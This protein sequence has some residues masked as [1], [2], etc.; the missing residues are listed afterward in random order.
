MRTSCA[1]VLTRLHA[2]PSLLLLLL[3]PCSSASQHW[4]AISQS[5]FAPPN[6]ATWQPSQGQRQPPQGHALPNQRF[7][8]VQWQEPRHG[9]GDR[10]A[11]HG[12]DGGPAAAW[13]FPAEPTA[14]PAAAAR[15]HPGHAAAAAEQKYRHEQSM[16]HYLPQP[17]PQPPH[18]Q[19]TRPCLPRASPISQCQLYDQE[20]G[21]AVT[22]MQDQQPA[23][24]NFPPMMQQQHP[25]D[26]WR[27]SNAAG[28]AAAWN[29]APLPSL[30]EA[31]RPAAPQPR[32]PGT[33]GVMSPARR[34]SS[35]AGDVGPWQPSHQTRYPPGWERP[36]SAGPQ[37][38]R[39]GGHPAQSSYS[40]YAAQQWDQGQH[41]GHRFQQ[42][43]EE[44]QRLHQQADDR[45]HADQARRH[46]EQQRQ[47]VAAQQKQQEQDRQWREIR[48]KLAAK[49][50]DGATAGLLSAH[51][52]G[53]A[54]P[55]FLQQ[56]VIEASARCGVQK[57]IET[58]TVC[59]GRGAILDTSD[60]KSSQE[61]G[62]KHHVVA[63]AASAADDD[64]ITNEVEADKAPPTSDSEARVTT[65][66]LLKLDVET[67]V[68]M[69]NGLV[70]ELAFQ[71]AVIRV[72]LNLAL[73][74]AGEAVLIVPRGAS[75]GD[76]EDALREPGLAVDAIAA[77]GGSHGSEEDDG[78]SGA[79][80]ADTSDGEDASASSEVD[81]APEHMT[82]RGCAAMPTLNGRYQQTRDY[83][84]FGV[85]HAVYKSN[86]GMLCFFWKFSKVRVGWWLGKIFGSNESLVGFCPELSSTL[87]ESGWHIEKESR[88]QSDPATFASD[89]ALAIEAILTP[90]P[91]AERINTLNKTVSMFMGSV[92]AE[93]AATTAYFGHFSTLIHLEYLEDV[94]SMRRRLKR[95]IAGLVKGGWA[96][97]DLQETNR[98]P[99]KSGVVLRFRSA[100]KIDVSRTRFKKGDAVVLSKTNPIVDMVADG[101]VV[102]VKESAVTIALDKQSTWSQPKGQSW[103]VDKAANR[104]SYTR[105][106][107]SLEKICGNGLPTRSKGKKSYERPPLFELITSSAVGA[108]DSWA[109]VLKDGSDPG[110][111]TCKSP[112][113]VDPPPPD[114]ALPS[115]P[116]R[117]SPFKAEIRSIVDDLILRVVQRTVAS[118]CSDG[119]GGGG[120]G[121]AG[122]SGSGAGGSANA[123]EGDVDRESA[124]LQALATAAA[125]PVPAQDALEQCKRDI[126]GE[127]NLNASQ[128]AAV[129]AALVRRCSLIQGP[130]G[131]GKT[132][133][134]VQVLKQW[135]NLGLR[136]I[137]ATADGNIAVDNIAEGL[138]KSGLRVVRVGQAGKVS[139]HLSAVLLDNLVAEERARRNEARVK[140][141]QLDADA[142]IAEGMSQYAKK[143]EPL[144]DPD[145]QVRFAKLTAVPEDD[146]I[147]VAGAAT[148]DKTR[149][150]STLVFRNCTVAT[151]L[152]GI[153]ELQPS[154]QTKP[155][156][157]PLYATP[158]S[159][160]N[161]VY[162]FYG[163]FKGRTGWCFGRKPRSKKGHL[164]FCG[165]EALLPPA[166]GWR[167]KQGGEELA[168][169]GGF[170]RV[171]ECRQT[172]IDMLLDAHRLVLQGSVEA[173][174]KA[175]N[176]AAP[177]DK[178]DFR[179]TMDIRLEI[180]QNADVVCAQMI[181][182]GGALLN[183]LGPFK[184]ILVDE[185]A[186]STEPGV[187]VP[188]VQRGCER[189]VLVGDHCQLPPTVQS[190][191]AQQRGLSLSLY[192][193][194][195]ELG[196]Q[197]FFLDTQYRS[198]PKLMEFVSDKIYDG[199]LRSGIGSD[200]RPPVAG[201]S[202]PR[203][204][205]PLAF[206]EMGS[207]AREHSDGGESKSNPKEAARVMA[208]LKEVLAAGEL[209]CEQ[210]GIITPYMGQ[211]RLLRQ[212]WR[213]QRSRAGKGGANNS[214]K[215]MANVEAP[216]PDIGDPA[217][218]EIA[219]VDNFQGREKELIIF[220]AVRSNR[221]GRVGFL[222][223]WRRL[224]VML[225]RA[226]R[227]LVVVGSS[228]TLQHDP[229][230]QQWLE[231]AEKHQ[232]VIDPEAWQQLVHHAISTMPA[233]AVTLRRAASKLL[234][235]DHVSL[236]PNAFKR[237]AKALGIEADV[238]EKVWI[239]MLAAQRG[240]RGWHHA[241]DEALRAGGGE[242]SWSTLRKGMV[243]R[244]AETHAES[245]GNKL[246]G[247]ELK[248]FVKIEYW[249]DDRK[250]VKMV[251]SK[252]VAAPAAGRGGRGG[253]RGWGGQAARGGRSSFS[254]GR[255]DGRGRSGRGRGRGRALQLQAPHHP[256]QP[257]TATD[258]SAPNATVGAVQHAASLQR[259]KKKAKV[260]MKAKADVEPVLEALAAATPTRRAQNRKPA[261]AQLPA[262]LTPV[263][264]AGADAD[265]TRGKPRLSKKR[266][267]ASGVH[268][269]SNLGS[270]PAEVEA[271]RPTAKRLKIKM[272]TLKNKKNKNK[273]K[274]EK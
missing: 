1:A 72:L 185:V 172:M 108:V 205:V 249:S 196:V 265:D 44:L 200:A 19:T 187:I 229:L 82:F 163:S 122:S 251:I 18:R 222:S 125:K 272:S 146:G 61:D 255:S 91:V 168:D 231:W 29:A 80:D 30:D 209:T 198:H 212:L 109:A 47:R 116:S 118:G 95:D 36:D 254:G 79:S 77:G 219:S 78:A 140:Q 182:A 180:L 90:I 106:F 55:V 239:V 223:D 150:P 96:F 10:G 192:G 124:R 51:R 184:A 259:P 210:I 207:H 128:K 244:Y 147:A 103:R 102:D 173:V 148:Q 12:H 165:S 58:L 23:Q 225:T 206:W 41:D 139:A 113:T 121:G 94:S 174:A 268:P 28:H 208:I 227:G 240:W 71:P 9:S 46:S 149:W 263:A 228:A 252:T 188:I 248:A 142:L 183:K 131:T 42:E 218:L 98:S 73:P 22:P 8:G 16:T 89:E 104:V 6:Q 250:H 37:P 4:H 144:S 70:S 54:V 169:L 112:P 267:R 145:L 34:R 170:F 242:L 238:V 53:F 241:V 117:E 197:P 215:G 167:I 134:S 33:I 160:E 21:Q 45:H 269:V 5:G 107:N 195:V 138:V 193:R 181:S 56:L 179:E 75:E 162:V 133:T 157:W 7:G 62:G 119:G 175:G 66:G 49:D 156:S 31:Y 120:G 203:Q 204:K 129:E 76:M 14:G 159:T 40:P 190:E 220:S 115:A 64:T 32:V 25:R 87:P 260:D 230:W 38:W 86:E 136:P 99:K 52:A 93:D 274:K 15:S 270:T 176:K 152:N 57:L 234:Q 262:I 257:V 130:P 202:W 74:D 211:V 39:Q 126:G 114:D 161:R 186:Q 132:S 143:L 171:R 271:P 137:L 105:Q 59:S 217:R 264:S 100:S 166:A 13:N 221:G 178:D 84:A 48:S 69:M 24:F 245:E 111:S 123:A 97:G 67:Y 256:V 247:A 110:T 253:G 273:K 43:Q 243:K 154:G 214:G 235:L 35:S 216:P 85:A 258:T 17:Q 3:A 153:F 164:G 237:A 155:P 2:P 246:T 26:E 63:A 20:Y 233:T 177:A 141:A 83:D 81:A 199:L 27:P 88:R 50:V 101:S 189:L 194:L 68:A 158:A 92:Y 261:A 224:N 232:V 236:R 201:F 127:P 151:E 213:E 65:Q 266:K 135:S 226:R 191:E 60:N 11:G